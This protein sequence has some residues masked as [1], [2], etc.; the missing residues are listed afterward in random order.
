[1]RKNCL[2]SYWGNHAI[3]IGMV[4][5]LIHTKTIGHII[6]MGIVG[7]SYII[8]LSYARI[9]YRWSAQKIFRIL[10]QSYFLVDSVYYTNTK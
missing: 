2:L 6:P 3:Y 7:F 5:F 9:L 4:G 10:Y 1:M 8:P